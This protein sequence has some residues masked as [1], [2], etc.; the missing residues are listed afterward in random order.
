MAAFSARDR[1]RTV[2]SDW[3]LAAGRRLSS[4]SIFQGTAAGG[5]GRAY[6]TGPAKLAHWQMQCR[7]GDKIMAARIRHIALSVK[8]IDATADF[9]EKAFGLSAHRN[10]KGRPHT[11]ST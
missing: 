11:A 8:D 3:K 6:G 4:T 5:K 10:P 1:I 2:N 7:D 9:Y